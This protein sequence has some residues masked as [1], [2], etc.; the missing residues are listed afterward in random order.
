MNN[1]ED[2]FRK[3]QDK[4]IEQPS[5]RTWQQLERRL[6]DHRQRGRRTLYQQFAMAAAV[7][8]LVGIVGFLATA[9]NT[10]TTNNSM[11]LNTPQFEEL[12]IP[13]EGISATKVSEYQ[14]QYEAATVVIDEGTTNKRLVLASW[15]QK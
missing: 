10:A 4:L 1:I 6:D 8:L 2:L 12:S 9:V 14:K 15:V 13:S 3:N 7:L 5:A 11:V